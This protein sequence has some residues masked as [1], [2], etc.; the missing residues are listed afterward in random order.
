M[1]SAQRQDL[2]VNYISLHGAT[3]VQTLV[4]TLHYSTATINRDLNELQKLGRVRRSYGIVERYDQTYSIPKARREHHLEIKRALSQKAAEMVKDNDTIFLDSST[5]VECMGEFL[6]EKRNLT[7]ITNNAVLGYLCDFG[8]R[9][10]ILGGRVIEIPYVYGDYSTVELIQTFRANKFFFSV[11]GMSC[12]GE[13]NDYGEM[14]HGIRRAMM[15]QSDQSFLLL[16][17]EKWGRQNN[18]ILTTLDSVSGVI[19]DR[20][21]P[22]EFTRLFPGTVFTRVYTDS[23]KDN[24]PEEKA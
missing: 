21:Y 14:I 12:A 10:I 7:V 24:N 20:D 1:H 16:D 17:K 23:G 8:V 4:D 5:T 19:S 15:R 13:L 2:I 22:E 11:A 9:V 18:R 3:S 6:R